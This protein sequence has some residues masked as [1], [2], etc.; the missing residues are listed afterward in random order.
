MPGEKLTYKKVSYYGAGRL[1][2]KGKTSLPA[3]GFDG[4]KTIINAMDAHKIFRGENTNDAPQWFV[5]PIQQTRKID[6]KKGT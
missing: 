4:D 6:G 2:I 5:E 1:S 3:L